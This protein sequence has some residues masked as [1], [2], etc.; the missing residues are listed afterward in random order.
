MGIPEMENCVSKG[1]EQEGGECLAGFQ[2][3]CRGIR[4]DK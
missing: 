1:R 3:A 4:L 2:H